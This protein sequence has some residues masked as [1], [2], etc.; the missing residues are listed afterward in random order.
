[1]DIYEVK[2]GESLYI[3]ARTFGT[4]VEELVRLNNIEDPDDISA[5]QQLLVPAADP[6]TGT[7]GAAGMTRQADRT[8]ATTTVDGLRYILITDR[9]QYQRGEQVL[10]TFIKCNVSS[11]TIV[12]NYP[13]AQRFDV[14]ALRDGREVWRWSDGRFFAQ[15]TGTERLRPGDCRTYTATWDLRNKQGNF[16][17][18]DTF[19]IRAENVAA[20]LRNR[21]VQARIKVVSRP[22][23]PAPSPGR[24]PKTN[25]LAN[26]GFEEWV[27]PTTPR[28]WAATNVR[29]SRLAHDGIYAAELGRDPGR[30]G[31]LRQSVPAGPRL[32]YQI[33]FWTRERIRDSGM[34]RYILEAAVYVYDRAG[35]FIGRVDPVF[36]PAVIPDRTYQQYRFTTGVLPTGTDR[37][38]L[39]FIFRPRT[40][41]N[42]SV[43]I[44]DVE[45]I[46][47]S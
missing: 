29:R 38:E 42:N 40:G 26:P 43:I 27:N 10:I 47:I 30:Q 32:N 22:R 31:V 1:M 9:R 3:I 14:V 45:M 23:P 13:T 33:T 18:P 39:R 16:V 12:L 21:F 41:N 28:I 2:A 7:G 4:T 36:S 19:T 15:V 8:Y 5:G 20:E 25:M 44:D 24:C 37:A 11:G 46:C 34:S 35:N 6:G 17:A